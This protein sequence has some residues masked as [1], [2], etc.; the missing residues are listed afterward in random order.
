MFSPFLLFSALFSVIALALGIALSVV[1]GFELPFVYLGGVNGAALFLFGLDKSLARGFSLGRG[2]E[3]PRLRK[4]EIRGSVRAKSHDTRSS[5]L[6]WWS[7]AW[8][9]PELVFYGI[10]AL[11][12]SV[13]LL[14]GMPL[15][16]HK[17]KK[18]RFQFT[19][20]AILIAQLLVLRAILG[21]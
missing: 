5:L 8:R 4:D 12:G 13:A 18:G 14:V 19:I 10:A 2:A 7:G 16:R 3:E 11:G 20:A 6:R 9:V 17:T 1:S 21:A 15:F